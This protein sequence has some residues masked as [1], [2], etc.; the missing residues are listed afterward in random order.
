M[1]VMS[2]HK[3]NITSITESNKYLFKSVAIRD[4]LCALNCALIETFKGITPGF[5][6]TA[7]NKYA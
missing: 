6:E 2:R 5:C 7:E 1:V 3:Y 4:F